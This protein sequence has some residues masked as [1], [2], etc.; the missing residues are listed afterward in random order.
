MSFGPRPMYSC[1]NRLT[2]SQIAASIS[3][4]VFI[5]NLA[6]ETGRA[7]QSATQGGG[8]TCESE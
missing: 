5:R 2:P 1:S 7:A 4:C 8:R 3:P 6:H